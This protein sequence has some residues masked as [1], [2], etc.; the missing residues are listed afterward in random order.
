MNLASHWIGAIAADH[1]RNEAAAM[2]AVEQAAS[3]T[4]DEARGLV[5]LFADNQR[6]LGVERLDPPLID[7]AGAA[8]LEALVARLESGIVLASGGP[9][10][11]PPGSSLRYVDA[12]AI[13]DFLLAISDPTI[14]YLLISIGMLGL[15]IEM[16]HPG[17]VLPGVVGSVCLLLGVYSGGV[18]EAN[19]AGLLLMVLA[20]A[21]LLAEAFTPTFGLLFAGGM[22]SLV[23][24][25]L[26]LFSGTPFEVEPWVMGVVIGAIGLVFILVVVVVIRAQRLPVN[27]GREGLI[28]Q[29]A[30]VRSPLDPRG[31]VFVEGE[32]WNAW[33]EGGRADQGDEVTC[34]RR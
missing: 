30:V 2:A 32:I 5:P 1:G 4:A 29:T 23:A 12:T 11:I 27:T 33:M 31:T 14:A 10:R 20:F 24:G 21:L 7:D 28:G 9:F 6:Y 18:L 3:F 26:L 15:L 16:L 22:V 19:Y 17:V 34:A 13:E 25:S 8:D